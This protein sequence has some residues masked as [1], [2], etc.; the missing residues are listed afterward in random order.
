MKL[1]HRRNVLALAAVIVLTTGA[2]ACPRKEQVRKAR[3]SAHVVQVTIDA[4]VDSLVALHSKKKPNGELYVSDPDT[5][6][7]AQFLT[8]VNDANKVFIASA[9]NAKDLDVS[10]KSIL[11]TDLQDVINAV[12]ELKASGILGV[13]SETGELAFQTAINTLDSS[14]KILKELL[15]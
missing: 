3:E 15:Q 12:G 2:W 10:T 5:L 8:K 9:K 4:S 7:Y 6:R 1:I 11:L 13:K 14:L